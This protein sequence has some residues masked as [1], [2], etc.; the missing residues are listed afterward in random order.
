MQP[1]LQVLNNNNI[2]HW[3]DYVSTWWIKNE[4]KKFKLRRHFD[5]KR[6][7]KI[8]SEDMEI[9]LKQLWSILISIF[10]FLL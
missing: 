1:I 3:L 8:V 2:S 6:Q 7:S 4:E 5:V 10:L 9:V